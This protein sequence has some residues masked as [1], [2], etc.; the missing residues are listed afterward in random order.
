[1]SSGGR[2]RDSSNDSRLSGSSG[3]SP[4]MKNHLNQM[5]TPNQGIS[6]HPMLMNTGSIV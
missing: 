3:I 2:D 4:G 1:M 5:D 6:H